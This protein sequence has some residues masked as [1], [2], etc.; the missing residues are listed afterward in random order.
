MTKKKG[1]RLGMARVENNNKP[2]IT[3]IKVG[4]CGMTRALHCWWECKIVQSFQKV[5]QLPVPSPNVLV[6]YS[7]YNKLPQTYC[8]KKHC[9]TVLA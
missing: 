7:C 2:D 5:C 9:I 4:G 8:L 6:F 3:K 1:N